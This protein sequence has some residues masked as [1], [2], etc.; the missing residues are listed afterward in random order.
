MNCE[1]LGLSIDTLFSR[2]AWT[3]TIKGTFGAEIPFPIIE[4]VEREVAGAH[5]MA[6]PGAADT[7]AVRATFFSDAD[8]NLRAMVYSPMSNGMLDRRVR[9]LAAGHADQR[10]ERHRHPRRLDAGLRPHR[11]AARD[12]RGGGRAAG[13][14]PFPPAS[15]HRSDLP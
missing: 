8:G 7:Q 11:V 10:R 15:S 14:N 4:D 9:A 13:R 5:G 2:L 12:R 3:Q 6:H 1:L